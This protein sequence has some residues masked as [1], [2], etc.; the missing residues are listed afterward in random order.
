MFKNP[1]SVTDDAHDKLKDGRIFPECEG[2]SNWRA[3]QSLLAAAT[4]DK[5]T[6]SQL[7]ALQP[8]REEMKVESRNLVGCEPSRSIAHVMNQ[9]AKIREVTIHTKLHAH[10]KEERVTVITIIEDDVIMTNV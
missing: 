4:R 10:P 6:N 7:A 2:P 8:I 9:I 3:N 1:E 5:V